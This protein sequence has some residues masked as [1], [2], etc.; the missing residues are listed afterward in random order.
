MSSIG[1]GGIRTLVTGYS[2]CHLMPNSHIA[3]FVLLVSGFS[4]V[5]KMSKQ[6]ECVTLDF[7][8]LQGVLNGYKNI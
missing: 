3:S 1:V 2:R 8:S 4:S 6:L 7:D 5:V